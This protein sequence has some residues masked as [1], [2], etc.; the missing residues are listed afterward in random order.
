MIKDKDS[1]PLG[2]GAYRIAMTLICGLTLMLST[3][4]KTSQVATAPDN[5]RPRQDTA[6][7]D[8]EKE[9][10]KAMISAPT[11]PNIDNP[12]TRKARKN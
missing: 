7:S 2:K 8:D 1:S 4:C 9:A 10:I 11:I 6:Q 12:A 5:E 3:Q